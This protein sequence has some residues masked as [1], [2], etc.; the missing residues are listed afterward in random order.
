[1]LK[2]LRIK[3]IVLN[4]VI[5]AAVLILTFSAVCV[6][7][8]QQSI[9]QITEELDVT[10]SHVGNPDD[11]R[12]QRKPFGF[13]RFDFLDPFED[14]NFDP[15]TTDS[16][17][18]SEDAQPPQSDS[19]AALPPRIGGPEEDR[20]LPI[21]TYVLR[22][23]SLIELAKHST[24]SIDEDMLTQAATEVAEVPDGHGELH[25]LGL[26]YAKRT[27]N[28]ESYVAFADASA[29]NSWQSVALILAGVGVGA[30][31]VFFVISLFFSKWALAPV[32]KAW[33]KQR[34][35][36]AD[37]SHDLKTP[38]TV[39]LANSA[40]LE[41]HPEKTVAD[42]MQWVESTEHEALSMQALVGDLLTLA[43]IDEAETLSQSAT[44]G[45]SLDL[46]DFSDL[47]EGELLQMES[48]AFEH[49]IEL[50]STVAS[51]V[52]VS[53]EAA[54]LRRIVTTLVDN[55]CKYAGAGQMVS[56]HL[57]T[58]NRKAVLQVHNTGSAIDPAD[59]PH[60]FDRFYRADKARNRND[61]GGHGLG[62]AIAQA[63]AEESGGSITAQSTEA[64]GTTFT[65]TLP[66]G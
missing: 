58:A 17:T 15:L 61:I 63:L 39:I 54:H 50:T 41:E 59:L 34:Q 29:A 33:E 24:A 38:L 7:D 25:N 6:L 60:I 11:P 28:D 65:L 10:L 20:A 42:Q 32:A 30:L 21:A 52:F 27:L 55:A 62:L 26:F 43:R 13:D 51:G 44:T 64:D 37:A 31:G 5:A 22:D 46:V 4:M 45:A 8:Y 40:I 16:Q 12:H 19:E 35:F 3:F 9:N 23:A 14:T 2:R 47:V 57:R 66:L 49:G 18:P 1:M 48:L 53:G 56:V 36:I